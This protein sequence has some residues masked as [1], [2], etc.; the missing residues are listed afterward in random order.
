MNIPAAILKP[1]N[2]VKTVYPKETV[3]REQNTKL[4]RTVSQ[5]TST[6]KKK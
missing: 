4:V 5:A 2:C 3:G 1:V 6:I